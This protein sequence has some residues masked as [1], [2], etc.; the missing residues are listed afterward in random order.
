M[1]YKNLQADYTRKT[2]QIAEQRRQYEQYG[3]P[4]EIEQ[5]VQLYQS[6]Q[7]PQ[8]W[9]ALYEELRTNLEQMGYTPAEAAAAAN[10]EVQ[11]QA[12]QQQA[13]PIDFSNIQD[14]ELQPFAE[15]YK[16]LQDEVETM[17]A[18]LR[19]EREQERIAQQ[20]QALIGELQRQ[21]NLIRQGNPHYTDEDVGAVY[22]LASYHNGN[23]LEA[24]QRYED[25]IASRLERFLAQKSAVAQQGAAPLPGGGVQTQEPAVFGN[26]D[27]AHDAAMEYLRQ[28]DAFGD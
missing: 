20:Q 26:L 17:K 5:A 6:L 22:E 14:P 15:A 12:N 8:Y 18:E 27:D 11:Q 23:L 9:P 7:D 16:S 1:I 4:E 21:E 28:V 2:Q 10:Q 19:A 3:Q 24:Q 13:S 25:I